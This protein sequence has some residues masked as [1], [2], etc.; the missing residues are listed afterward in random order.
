[1]EKGGEDQDGGVSQ[2]GG[3]AAAAVM[4]HQPPESSLPPT[5]GEPGAVQEQEQTDPSIATEPPPPP[6][7]PTDGQQEATE[8][9]PLPKEEPTSEELTQPPAEAAEAPTDP[10]ESDQ[11]DVKVENTSDPPA[12]EEQPEQ[13]S[14]RVRTITLTSDYRQQEQQS[15]IVYAQQAEEQP[16]HMKIDADENGQAQQQ[17]APD[18][19]YFSQEQQQGH[20]PSEAVNDGDV[21]RYQQVSSSGGGGPSVSKME[22]LNAAAAEAGVPTG[23]YTIMVIL[24]FSL[25]AMARQVLFLIAQME[26]DE[27]GQGSSSVYLGSRLATYKVNNNE[28]WTNLT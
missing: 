14:H 28:K 21:H 25:S 10:P 20:Y 19:E 3:A 6:P 2:G 7:A 13:G 15:L 5:D 12:E 16:P 9:K 17:M 8:E 26:D 1:M 22:L 24:P 23:H 27:D 11:V 4:D 18:G